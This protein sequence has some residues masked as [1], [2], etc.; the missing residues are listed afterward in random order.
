[1]R[2][3]VKQMR[4]EAKEMPEKEAVFKLKRERR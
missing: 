2:K 4:K 1:M 3:E